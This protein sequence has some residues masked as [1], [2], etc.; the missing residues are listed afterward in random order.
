MEHINL[1]RYIRERM[2]PILA[3]E[4]KEVQEAYIHA[5]TKAHRQQL[6]AI[7]APMLVEHGL[8]LRFDEVV[9]HDTFKKLP[10]TEPPNDT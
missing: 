6:N 9:Y 4:S 8:K 5:R 7:V 10:A 1:K 2:D 3:T